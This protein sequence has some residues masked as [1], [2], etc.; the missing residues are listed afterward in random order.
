M[1]GKEKMKKLTKND[2]FSA[3]ILPVAVSFMLFIL[4]PTEIYFNNIDEFG[5]DLYNLLQAMLPIFIISA[6]VLSVIF[7]VA[8]KRSEKLF[9]I[10]SCAALAFFVFLFIV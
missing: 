5:Y 10:L 4:A 1:I 7:I 6:A 3:I 2:A 9:S 8:L